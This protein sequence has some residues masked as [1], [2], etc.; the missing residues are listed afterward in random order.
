MFQ[1]SFKVRL[2]NLIK[3]KRLN[4]TF[5]KMLTRI[6][7]FLFLSDDFMK[8]SN[9]VWKKEETEKMKHNIQLSEKKDLCKLK[10]VM[11][12]KQRNR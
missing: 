10:L 8:R 4:L 2:K 12:D 1:F 5:K 3:K 9:I 7:R 11:R 6:S